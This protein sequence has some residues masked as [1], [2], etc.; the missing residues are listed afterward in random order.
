MAAWDADGSVTEPQWKGGADPQRDRPRDTRGWPGSP[1]H[2]P[3]PACR[4]GK[5]VGQPVEAAKHLIGDRPTVSRGMDPVTLGAAYR[6][7]GQIEHRRSAAHSLKSP[8]AASA[9]SSRW[10]YTSPP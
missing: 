1:R 7:A 9:S 2:G 5:Q 3:P 10:K 6:G 8:R 4:N